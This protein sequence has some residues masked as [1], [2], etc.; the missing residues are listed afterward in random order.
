MSDHSNNPVGQISLGAGLSSSIRQSALSRLDAG[1][2][3]GSS[4]KSIVAAGAPAPKVN[5][6]N[7]TAV[8][9]NS[10]DPLP[11]RRLGLHM[12]LR[13]NNAPGPRVDNIA[14]ALQRFFNVGPRHEPTADPKNEATNK[15]FPMQ[16]LQA[17]QH[18]DDIFPYQF[19]INGVNRYQKNS[20][21]RMVGGSIQGSVA[22]EGS[23]SVNVPPTPGNQFFPVGPL[24]NKPYVIYPPA[25]AAQMAMQKMQGINAEPAT[26]MAIAQGSINAA[27]PDS[28]WK[29]AAQTA[30]ANL[31]VNGALSQAHLIGQNAPQYPFG[32]PATAASSALQTFKALESYRSPVVVNAFSFQS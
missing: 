10:F 13:V 27:G 30:Q 3:S 24:R 25:F 23:S 18:W 7:P 8:S 6:S 5:V 20:S 26:K 21:F 32:N 9:I 17:R 12:S 16:I 19:S 1:A 11:G 22:G 28:A 2:L 15:R 31:K 29:N 4:V 14:D